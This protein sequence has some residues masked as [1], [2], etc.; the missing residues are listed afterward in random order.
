[1][2]NLTAMGQVGLKGMRGRIARK[3]APAISRRTPLDEDQVLAILGWALLGL[4]AFGT[5][6]LVRSLIEAGRVADT[7]A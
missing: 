6:K 2:V 3:A 1:M 7:T 5:V 4:Y